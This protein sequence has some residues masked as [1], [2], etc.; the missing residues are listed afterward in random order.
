MHGDRN[1]EVGV[2]CGSTDVYRV[3]FAV[4]VT[5]VPLNRRPVSGQLSLMIFAAVAR[6]VGVPTR[7]VSSQ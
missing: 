5:L 7:A 4:N 6:A 1:G 3:G 2:L